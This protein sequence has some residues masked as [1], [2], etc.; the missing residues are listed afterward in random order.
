[1]SANF[2]LVLFVTTGFI[3]IAGGTTIV[4][5]PYGGLVDAC[6]HKDLSYLN[7]NL[8]Y[9]HICILCAG[10]RYLRKGLVITTLVKKIRD[11]FT[12]KSSCSFGFF[13]NEGGGGPCQN[14]LSTFHKLYMSHLLLLGKFEYDGG[15]I[16]KVVL[17]C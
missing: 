6:N 8:Q 5:D 4:L 2:S 14:F 9:N 15:P 3:T 17:E 11:G 13:P 7:C 12:K 1:M 16:F 10:A